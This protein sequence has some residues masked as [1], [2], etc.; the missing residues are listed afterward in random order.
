MR[1][2][3]ISGKPIERIEWRLRAEPKSEPRSQSL[4][5]QGEIKASK[6]DWDGKANEFTRKVG[7]QHLLEK[8][9]RKYFLI[10][11]TIAFTFHPKYN[12]FSWFLIGHKTFVYFSLVHILLRIFV[13]NSHWNLLNIFLEYVDIGPL[14]G[15]WLMKFHVD[16]FLIWA[17]WNKLFLVIIL[18]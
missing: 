17:F 18:K 10:L 15:N 1:L 12:A 6:E 16:N 8:K 2:P 5:C 7:R 11:R 3:W 13:W 4:E 9:W 14:L